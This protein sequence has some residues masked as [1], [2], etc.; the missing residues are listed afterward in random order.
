MSLATID[1]FTRRAF[2]KA[3]IIGPRGPADG[4]FL[5]DFLLEH[6]LAFDGPVGVIE[7]LR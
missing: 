1:R 4:R 7:L 3:R 2:V 6:V 5:M